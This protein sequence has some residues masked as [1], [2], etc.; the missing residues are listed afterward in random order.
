MYYI[1]IYI[2]NEVFN[3]IDENDSTH[4]GLK[5]I[6]PSQHSSF[7]GWRFTKNGI[8]PCSEEQ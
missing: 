1:Y 5:Y 3:S 7:W 6:F 8:K 2:Y 4:N